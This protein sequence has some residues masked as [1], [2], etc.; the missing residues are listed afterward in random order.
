[1]YQRAV[2]LGRKSILVGHNNFNTPSD[3]VGASG[4]ASHPE[5]A[6]AA[7]DLSAIA[8][9]WRIP[10]LIAGLATDFDQSDAAGVDVLD[11]RGVDEGPVAEAGGAGTIEFPCHQIIAIGGVEA[12]IMLVRSAF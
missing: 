12:E 1:M 10:L 2:G 11:G 9:P 4:R 7:R 3:T 8:S 6:R 5:R